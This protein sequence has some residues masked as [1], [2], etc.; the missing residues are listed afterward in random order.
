MIPHL[1]GREKD[2]EPFGWNPEDT[3]WVAMVCLNSGVFT[4]R[5]V[6]RFF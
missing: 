5:P 2:L 1:R 6:L 4:P 3:E